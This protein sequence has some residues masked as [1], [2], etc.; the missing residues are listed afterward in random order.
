M[1]NTKSA[2]PGEAQDSSVA[3]FSQA[4]RERARKKLAKPGVTIRPKKNVPLF[5]VDDVHAGTFIRKLNGR[6]ERGILED[7]V[8]K[9]IA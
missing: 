5:H 2:A 1:T 9:V 7:G 8:F 3:A 4:I 6:V